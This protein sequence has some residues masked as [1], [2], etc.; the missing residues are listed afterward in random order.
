MSKTKGMTPDEMV[1]HLRKTGQLNDPAR[2]TMGEAAMMI[3]NVAGLVAAV[4]ALNKRV[5][6]LE[7]RPTLG[8]KP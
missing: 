3:G 5:K 6:A 4:E 7:M 1:E 2:M 8:P